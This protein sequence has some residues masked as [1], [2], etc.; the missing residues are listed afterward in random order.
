MLAL[1]R[2]NRLTVANLD[3][4]WLVGVAARELPDGSPGVEGAAD[5]DSVL[6][7]AERDAVLRTLEAFKW[8]VSAAATRLHLSRRTMYRKMHRHGLLRRAFAETASGRNLK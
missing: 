4:N 6:G 7:G 1:R 2:S 5:G 3:D 8:N